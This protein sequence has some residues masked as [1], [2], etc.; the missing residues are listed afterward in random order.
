MYKKPAYLA[1]GILAVIMVLFNTLMAE[2]LEKSIA[3]LVNGKQVA[4]D[5]SPF[6]YQGRV[7]VPV[8]FIAEELGSLVDWDGENGAVVI[9]DGGDLYLKGKN[10]SS[11]AGIMMN[12]VR[13]A[14]LKDILD[15]DRDGDLA[16]YRQGHGGGDRMDNDPL[17]VDIRKESEYNESHIPGAVWIAEAESMAE[18]DSIDKLKALLEEHAARGGRYE[19]VA[20]CYTGST[21]GLV[22]GA[23][24]ARGL[25]VK[26]MMY[27]FDIAWR[28]KKL[29]DRPVN[30]DMEDSSGKTL[31]CGG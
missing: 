13:A 1:A 8:R 17:V 21:S 18:K 5:Q 29:A 25:P 27:G 30:G 3:V 4:M 2:A 26:S 23:L 24:G 28:G 20:Y 11:G 16:D 10:H 9:R 19:V 15:D 12:L 6:M 22:A 14:E 7:F 31:K